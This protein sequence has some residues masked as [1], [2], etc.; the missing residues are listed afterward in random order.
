MQ[1]AGDIGMNNPLKTRAD[2]QRAVIDLLIPAERYF[3][4]SRARV[5]LGPNSAHFSSLAAEVESFSRLLWGLVPLVAGGGAYAA[6]SLFLEGM[7]NGT[8]PGHPEFW[9]VPDDFDHRF[10]DAA[11]LGYAFCLAPDLFWHPMPAR[12]RRNLTRWLAVINSK[13]LHDNNWVVFRVLVNLGLRNVGAEFDASSMRRDL[14]RLGSFARGDGWYSDGAGQPCDYY[15]SYV[16]HFYAMV[17]IRLSSACDELSR[18]LRDRANQ[19]AHEF[20][21]WFAPDGAALPY[22]RSLVYRF[23]HVS[24]WSGLSLANLAPVSWGVIKGI[25]LRHL[26][27]WLGRPIFSETGLLTVGYA[28]ANSAVGEQYVSPGS[29]YWS[30]KAFACLAVPESHPFWS[31]TEESLPA[32]S[33][34]TV[35]KS[36]NMIVCRHRGHVFALSGGQTSS[37]RPRHFSEK[38]ARFCY[39][40]RYGLSRSASPSGMELLA[41]ENT[42][43]VGEDLDCMHERRAPES[44]EVHDDHIATVWRRS[45]ERRVGKDGR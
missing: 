14:A 1:R 16:M 26:R 37:S 33:Q 29:P 3:S 34:T 20:L 45:E 6:T 5:R 13:K 7:M 44:V 12:Q 40:P 30:L 42:L 32:L 4:P 10:V 15:N 41:P 39:S 8:D 36:T 19:F 21:N 18:L 11:A 17:Y 35:Q 27:W 22:G 28:Y 23:A 43:L 38:Y 9:G 25:V 2:V 31:S 24:F